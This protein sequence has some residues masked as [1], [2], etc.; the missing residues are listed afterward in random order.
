M[1]KEL[2]VH[3][4]LYRGRKIQIYTDAHAPNPRTEHDNLGIMFCFHKRYSLGDKHEHTDVARFKEMLQEWKVADVVLELPLF[5][6]DHGGVTI[7]NSNECY[8]FNDRWDAGQLGVI[9]ALKCAVEEYFG[10]WNT[11]TKELALQALRAETK[12]YDTFL[13]G[14]FLQVLV[15]DKDNEQI[16][17]C[18]GYESQEQ[19]IEDAKHE[20]DAHL[21]VEV[22]F[23]IEPIDTGHMAPRFKC[24]MTRADKNANP[25]TNIG[26]TARCIDVT[27]LKALTKTLSSYAEAYVSLIEE[28]VN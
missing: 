17:Q 18:G 9:V 20:I 14:G 28:G 26:I 8:P 23:V 3:E 15:T 4:E 21:V 25:K 6:Y 10:A 12:T 27:P 1:D 5:M 2:L 22:E 13:T 19:A 7:G 16:F 11:E 24:S